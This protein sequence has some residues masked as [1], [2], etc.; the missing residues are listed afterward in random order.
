MSDLKDKSSES[1]LNELIP[2]FSNRGLVLG[3]DRIRSALHQMND[4]CENIPAI[5]V[6]GTNGKGS[7]CSFIESCLLNTSI[8]VGMTT[9]PHLVSWCER[10]RINGEMISSVDLKHI[11]LKL[12]PIFEYH[13]LTPFESIL[14]VA[15]DYF[16]IKKV[17]ILILEVGLGGRLDATTVHPNR[18]IIAIGAIG[19]DHC[20]H[21]GKTIKE[22]TLE[23]ISV[24]TE[25]CHVVSC[26]Q[27]DEV[28]EIIE[29]KAKEK[30]ATLKWVDPIEK[31]W[32]LGIPGKIQRQNAAV[33]K[34]AIE[35]LSHIGLK[36]SQKA[37]KEGLAK[38]KWPGRLQSAT[39][40]NYPLLID[41]A[42]NPQASKELSIE[43]SNWNNQKNGVNWIIGIQ[44]NKEGPKIL[45]I[46]LKKNDLAWIVPIPGHKSWSK[47]DLQKKCHDLSGQIKNAS[48]VEDCL[49]TLYEKG[50]PN[51]PPV[52]TGSLYLLG[53]LF[54]K[55][56][57]ETQ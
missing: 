30:N 29:Q 32:A 48:S 35:A 4:P 17:D 10:I 9:S 19:I 57:I 7:I 51:P 44:A 37:I 52:V 16:S 28:R 43:R 39:W 22:I 47:F 3:L 20:E 18:P 55:K 8:K 50:W 38:A 23:K 6:I 25:G 46:L 42:H 26:I 13:K 24:L 15:F 5:Q 45:R 21:L 54:S 40:K 14:T 1:T 49:L 53:D 36:L 31:D 33:A 34:G 27:K 12:K 41:G 56:L 11:F 2:K